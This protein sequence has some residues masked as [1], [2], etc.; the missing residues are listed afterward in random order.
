MSAVAILGPG[1]IGGLL[2]V[3]LG[4][5]GHEVTLIGRHPD[6]VTAAGLT[7][8]APGED[9]ITT[10]PAS[11]PYLTEPVDVLIVAVKATQLVDATARVPA[12]LLA[13]ATV[14]PFLNG[15]DHVPYLRAV[16]PGDTVAA[17]IVV[18]ATKLADGTIEQVFPFARVTVATPPGSPAAAAAAKLFDVPGLQVATGP[19]EAQVL[20]QTLTFLATYALLTTAAG[21]PIGPAREQFAEWISPLIREACAAAAVQGARIDPAAVES[22]LR[23]LR[24]RGVPRYSRTAWPG[25]SSNSTPSRGPRSAPSARQRPRSRSGP[26]RPSWAPA[27]IGRRR[28]ARP[29]TAVKAIVCVHQAGSAQWARNASIERSSRWPEAARRGRNSMTVCLQY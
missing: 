21:Q 25:T 20:W 10:T 17:T 22:Q 18:E 8:T 29:S 1:G 16:Y 28:G 24:A 4:Q 26:C 5:A 15:V 12:A 11:R 6:R 3:R 19:G 9:P 7:L 27:D 14:V 23:G 2:A 13:G